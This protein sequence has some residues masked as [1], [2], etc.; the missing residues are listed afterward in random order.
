MLRKKII[1][2]QPENSGDIG[3]RKMFVF[4]LAA[5]LLAL[6][7]CGTASDETPAPEIVGLQAPDFTLDNALGGQTSLADYSGEP[8][9]LY[10]HMAVG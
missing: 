7:A 10:F 9:L 2:V 3:M 5:G 6:T 8:V 1:G 4:V